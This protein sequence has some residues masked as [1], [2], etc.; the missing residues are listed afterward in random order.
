MQLVRGAH[1]RHDI[2]R[3]G[4]PARAGTAAGALVLAVLVLTACSSSKSPATAGSH[5]TT[6]TAAGA[7]AG[8]P[9]DVA[10]IK[11]AYVKL[12]A[13]STPMDT[14]VSLLQDGEAFRATLIEQGKS[15]Y[16]KEA[17]ATVSKVVVISP[18]RANVTFSILLNGSP[19][20]PNQPGYAIRDKGVWKV[21]G[22][23]FC[24][25]LAAQGTPPAVCSQPAATAL[26]S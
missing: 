18:T 3:A 4:R 26:P 17:T 1:A 15:T 7:G 25:L 8:S 10:A 2:G 19:V 11:N 14:S 13:A 5:S 9:A 24:G 16:A 12:F 21:A 20:L 23:T 22:V 6:S